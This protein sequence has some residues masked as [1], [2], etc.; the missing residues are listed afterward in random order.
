MSDAAILASARSSGLAGESG[1]GLPPL[2][3][4]FM[5]AVLLPIRFWVGP[6][7]L[8]SV[9]LVVLAAIIPLTINLLRG[10]YG[11]VLPTDWLFMAHVIWMGISLAMTTP[12]A[13]VSQ[14]GSVGAEFYGGYLVGRASIRSPRNLSALVLMVA[15]SVVLLL[16]AVVYELKTGHPPVIDILRSLP[17][18]SSD[19][20]VSIDRR[21]NLERVQAVFS[22]P[23]HWGLYCS[24]VI[25][26]LF[27]GLKGAISDTKRYA[28]VTVV[29]FGT[30][31]SLSSGAILP[32]VLQLGLIAWAVAFRS[33]P[34]RWRILAGLFAVAWV[35]VDI[36]SNRSP[37]MVFL[38]RATFSSH[39][40]Y[41]RAQIFEWGMKNI[42]GS[43]EDAIPAARLFGI[44]FADWVRPHYMFS[45][46]MD[47]FWLVVGVRHGIPGFLT[48]GAGFIWLI[49]SVSRRRFEENTPVWRLRRAWVIAFFS[50]TL[51]LCTVH[52][53]T[54]VYAYTFFLLGAGA[55]FLSAPED[56]GA[57]AAE[58]EASEGPAARR[59]AY[60]RFAGRT[61]PQR[62]APVPA[63][64]LVPA[65]AR[66]AGE[67]RYA[68][69]G[70]DEVPAPGPAA[71][72]SPARDRTQRFS[73]GP[74]PGRPLKPR[75]A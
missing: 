70:P 32:I 12:E 74:E 37:L 23:I 27:V 45:G 7:M 44:G 69:G 62:P 73:R 19:E 40:A 34:A 22:H 50:L 58:A 24:S 68:R 28:L 38:S 41:W 3:L 52:I 54:A 65:A 9:R 6:L 30:F 31:S 26:L 42:F 48:L 60:S 16:P 66:G 21:M 64:A 5:L 47:N 20:I 46:S 43:P 55:W 71:P 35:V 56:G 14:M 39:N 1:R 25:A 13:A 8:T 57:P 15:W 29:I 53:W 61:G 75:G 11:R 33:V 51:T 59:T 10:R 63:P 17:L 18:V 2:A 49:W 36:L 72:P 4:A 67:I